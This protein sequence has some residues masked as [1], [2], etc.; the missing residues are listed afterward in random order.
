MQIVSAEFVKDKRVLVRMD[1]D[2]PLHFD[3][4]KWVVSESFRLEVGIPTLHLCLE[5]GKEVTVIGH[6]GRP[7]GI[8]VKDL[9]IE[10]IYDWFME[11]GFA[12]DLNNGRLKLLENLRFEK[13]EDEADLEY[14]KQLAEF[15]DCFVNEAFASHHKAASTTVLPTLLPHAAGL[16][17]AKEVHTLEN[18]RGNPQRPLVSLVG[19][20]KVEDKYDA[21]IA[22]SKFSDYVLVGGLLPQKIK[23]QSLEVPSNVRLGK[24]ND[25]GIDL[26]AESMNEFMSI[27]KTSKEVIWGGPM[28]KYED[29]RGNYSDLQLAQTIT[30][31]SIKSI[32]G[33]GDTISSLSQFL[34]KFDFVSSGGGAMLE[35]LSKGTLLTIEA[36]N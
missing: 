3:G 4:E 12:R 21:V 18:V 1:L 14:A 22:L 20:V 19:G 33:G 16:R 25:S 10:P 13:G 23:E 27:L 29:P 30:G 35:F 7:K 24:V 2:V 15:G 5:F 6:I 31:S 36:L 9:S 8:E 34:D 26:A 32:I 28:G 17:F 11:Y